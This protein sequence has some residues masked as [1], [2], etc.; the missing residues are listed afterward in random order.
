MSNALETETGVRRL[1][2][3]K[4][5]A[6][7]GTDGGCGGGIVKHMTCVGAAVDADERWPMSMKL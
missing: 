7:R 6:K 5:V 3:A 4:V 1:H 2:M